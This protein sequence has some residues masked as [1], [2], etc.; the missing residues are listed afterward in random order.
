MVL[1]KQTK[2]RR[3]SELQKG[4]KLKIKLAKTNA[5]SSAMISQYLLFTDTIHITIASSTEDSGV[6]RL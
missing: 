4:T 2:Q 3:R 6:R 5:E 1:F